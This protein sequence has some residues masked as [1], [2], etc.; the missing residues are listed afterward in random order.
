MR[1]RSLRPPGPPI[2]P[3]ELELLRTAEK[4]L[5]KRARVYWKP[6]DDAPKPLAR[7][8]VEAAKSVV[9]LDL[10]ILNAEA[11]AGMFKKPIELLSREIHYEPLPT[12]VRVA[13][14]AAW[15]RGGMLPR[16]GQGL[17]VIPSS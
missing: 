7:D 17:I 12:E 5:E 4:E 8:K 10:A 9:M 15:Q 1:Q 3:E 14:I 16:A 2:T 13:V 11:A 6:G